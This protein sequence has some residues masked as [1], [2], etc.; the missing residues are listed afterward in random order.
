MSN[1]P[2]DS[3]DLR[4]RGTKGVMSAIG[5]IGLFVVNGLLSIPVVGWVIAG[6]LV[7]LGVTGVL[8]R[9]KTDRTSGGIMMAAGALGLGAILLRGPTHFLLGAGG[10]ALLAYGAYN[11]YRFIRGLRDR[12]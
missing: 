5:G 4:N 9:S 11:I 12:A 2:V 10:F 8:G 3:G 7:V 6:G 1:Y